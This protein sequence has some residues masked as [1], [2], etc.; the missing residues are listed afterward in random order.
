TSVEIKKLF[1]KEEQEIIGI[2]GEYKNRTLKK[3]N[4]IAEYLASIDKRDGTT[5]NK[6]DPKQ[7]NKVVNQLSTE[8]DILLH[9]ECARELQ[10][11]IV[12]IVGTTHLIERESSTNIVISDKEKVKPTI[13]NDTNEVDE[14]QVKFQSMSTQEKN[15]GSHSTEMDSSIHNKVKEDITTSR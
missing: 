7:P 3:D 15:K 1:Q 12:R 10:E 11:E 9:L 4:A 6:Q 5:E 8:K 13:A 14:L 2:L